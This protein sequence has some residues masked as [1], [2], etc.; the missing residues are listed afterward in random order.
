MRVSKKSLLHF[1]HLESCSP[2]CPRWR[3]LASREWTSLS[4]VLTGLVLP[5]LP[6]LLLFEEARDTCAWRQ[7]FPDA[8][9]KEQSSFWHWL[10]LVS[11]ARDLPRQVF[12]DLKHIF[13][14][15]FAQR[16]TAVHDVRVVTINFIHKSFVTT[17]F[18]NPYGVSSWTHWW[19][20][21]FNT[22]SVNNCCHLRKTIFYFCIN[23][24]VWLWI[25]SVSMRCILS[26]SVIIKSTCNIVV[27]ILDRMVEFRRCTKI[28][29]F[30][31]KQILEHSLSRC[32]R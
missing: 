27:S 18:Q 24:C 28:F 22:R 21:H 31:R 14:V 25:L 15:V 10:N 5:P 30:A 17:T 29:K 6:A 13:E 4:D 11:F 3:S 23:W 20:L 9:L 7:W 16:G 1:R 26:P 8:C 32:M 12:E 2:K 19:Y